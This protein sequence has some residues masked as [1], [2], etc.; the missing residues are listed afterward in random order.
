MRPTLLVLA[1]LSLS[2]LADDSR[3][4]QVRDSI[5]W[6]R[7]YEDAYETLYC[8]RAK[9]A[10]EW[11]TVEH[12]YAASWIAKANGCTSRKNC[13]TDAYR[14][15]S[16]DLHNL[17]PALAR[18]NMSRGNQPFDEIPGETPRFSD[19][20]CDYERTSGAGAIVEP[21]DEVKGEISRS[22][23]YMIHQYDPY[24]Y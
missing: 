2:A 11:V 5:F 22:A 20:A 15:A 3:Y 19:D 16:F 8:E 12:I 10:G 6:P 24:D 9:A 23:L 17:W 18:Y 21:R 4:E 7:L 14:A 13:P 1:L